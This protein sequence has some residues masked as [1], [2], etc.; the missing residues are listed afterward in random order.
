M[1]TPLPPKPVTIIPGAI[2]TRIIVHRASKWNDPQ[3]R[4]SNHSYNVG[5]EAEVGVDADINAV[6]AAMEAECTTQ[7]D[8]C[9]AKM[10][11][12]AQIQADFER[13]KNE[14][15][16][17]VRDVRNYEDGHSR[18]AQAKAEANKAWT[19]MQGM[20]SALSAA[21]ITVEMPTPII[22][23]KPAPLAFGPR[24]D[25]PEDEDEDGDE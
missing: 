23:A 21:G 13:V 3:K 10:N 17:K 25:L 19:E 22:D 14:F 16:Y 18:Q 24:G 8:A 20:A 2:I 9:Q 15:G 7:V 4:Y 11:R 12:I 1:N 6:I 5:L